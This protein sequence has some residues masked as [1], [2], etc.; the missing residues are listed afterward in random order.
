MSKPSF[1]N[2][3]LWLF[4]YAEGNL[5]E[6]QVAQLELF[7]LQHPE[8]DVDRDMWEMAQVRKE[9]VAFNDQDSL[10]KRR[11]VGAYW[12]VG[13]GVTTMLLLIF[14]GYALFGTNDSERMKEQLGETVAY[15]EEYAYSLYEETATERELRQEVS[16]LKVL[17]TSLE[18]QLQEARGLTAMR[19]SNP[20]QNHTSVA[21]SNERTNSS[22][23]NGGAYDLRPMQNETN[24]TIANNSSTVSSVMGTTNAIL[25]NNSTSPAATNQSL[26]NAESLVDMQPMNS[27][28]SAVLAT[29]DLSAEPERRE[30]FRESVVSTDGSD[31]MVSTNEIQGRSVNY[32]G[33]Y[34]H[35]LS[36]L[37]R[38]LRNMSNNPIA[39]KNYRDA[40]HH[41]PGMTMT[42]LNFGATGAMISPRF[43]TM[44][45]IQGLGNSNELMT[46]QIGFD[47][48][49]LGA[50]GGLGV[51][52]THNY[53]NQGGI[54]SGEVAVTYSPK[55]SVNR[56]LSIEPAFRF[57]MGNKMLDSERMEG[58]EQVEFIPGNTIDYYQD[59]T[60]PVG[61]MLWYRDM[62]LGLNVN[63]EWFYASAQVDNIF[64]HEDH[65]YSNDLSEKRRAGTYFVATLGTD[66]ESND[67]QWETK[68]S[69]F[70]LSPYLVYRK[71]ENIN[72]LWAGANFRAY[73]L[74]IG[75]SISS[76]GDPAASLGIVS[77]DKRFSLMYNADYSQSYVTNER[78]LSHQ[79]TLRIVGKQSR[80]GRR[81]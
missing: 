60:T 42:D 26:A 48:Y 16:D 2:I 8:L 38:Q 59:G 45:R 31:V 15:S 7:I 39:L 54:Q 76:N 10:L 47:G 72:E 34:K 24:R 80:I 63:T 70:S 20:P 1:S 69:K 49:L 6:D 67:S 11:P 78:S 23:T 55:F 12:A 43:Q 21:A 33:S 30:L 62:G 74:S 25:A 18:S 5:T 68:R 81:N 37:V 19:S 41:V 28:E 32:E 65:M 46:N 66:W 52:M 53:Y 56:K 44:S 64:R 14:G 9:E 51:Q 58:T 75:A 73:W 4:E 61:R 40:Y 77:S 3:D 36:K 71:F 50:R 22:V 17:V 27:I 13:A 57:K 79:L 35:K 29:K